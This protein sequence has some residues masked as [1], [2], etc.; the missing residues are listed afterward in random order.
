M[1]LSTTYMGFKLP[2]PIIPGASPLGY[3]LDA[4]KQLEDAGAPM[5][6]M[7]SLFEEQIK[8]EQIATIRS[9]DEGSQSYGEALSYLPKADIFTLG[10]EEYL[11]RIAQLKKAVKIPVI[12][13]LNG[14]APGVWV[15][16]AKL[17]EQA[18][19]DGLELNIYEIA[20]ALEESGEQVEK[21]AIEIVEAVKSATRLPIAVKLAPFYSSFANFAHQLDRRN[22]NALVLFNRFYQPDIDVESLEVLR[23]NLSSSSELLLRLR[24][25]AV[26]SGRVNAALAA[27]GGVHTAVDVVKAIMTGAHA[28]QT[29]SAL[30]TH[31][32]G[33]LAILHKDLAAWLEK[34]EYES[35]AQMQG[36]MNL[37]RCPDPKAFE[38]AN[39]M[40]VLQSWKD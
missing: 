21:R 39:Y 16:Y 19:A 18:G 13:S 8:A 40:Q 32:P 14:S 23:V 3:S 15:E 24:W 37:L 31:G 1:D 22:V 11:D 34:H 12:A 10:P 6:V 28:V 38:R 36:S 30:L 29:V 33:Y 25:L 2:H 17:M 35:L 20:T 7:A 26:L 27:S 9:I 5:L 4:A